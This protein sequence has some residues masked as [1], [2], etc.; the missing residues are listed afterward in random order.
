[1]KERRE[2]IYK[3]QKQKIIKNR[4]IQY[5]IVWRSLSLLSSSKQRIARKVTR[6]VK[7]YKINYTALPSR[8]LHKF[9]YRKFLLA[10]NLVNKNVALLHCFFIFFWLISLKWLNLPDTFDCFQLFVFPFNLILSYFCYSVFGWM[11]WVGSGSY[12]TN[13]QNFLGGVFYILF[14]VH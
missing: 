13:F 6:W 7:Q 10:S 8:Q 2:G 14:Y 3:N 1:M 5:M 11:G 4:F 12:P 9:F